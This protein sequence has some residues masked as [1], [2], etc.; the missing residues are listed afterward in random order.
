MT[1]SDWARDF[2]RASFMQ[3]VEL[4]CVVLDK[5]AIAADKKADQ[6][7]MELYGTHFMAYSMALRDAVGLVREA[8]KEINE[9]HAEK[10]KTE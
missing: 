8:A 9:K 5:L 6:P 10:E 7:G 2:T 4:A 1:D 3:G